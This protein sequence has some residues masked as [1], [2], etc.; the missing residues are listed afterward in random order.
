[1]E[2]STANY[3]SPSHRVR[4]AQE[5]KRLTELLD[6]LD[7]EGERHDSLLWH[8]PGRER[9]QH[10]RHAK[11]RI[12]K[13]LALLRPA[14]AHEPGTAHRGSSDDVRQ[15]CQEI[16]TQWPRTEV[17]ALLRLALKRPHVYLSLTAESASDDDPA[18]SG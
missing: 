3:C 2:T 8:V 16:V 11:R 15:A 1:M 17:A 18:A 6:V 4:A 9:L 13:H 5:V 10:V 14:Q 7:S 12:E